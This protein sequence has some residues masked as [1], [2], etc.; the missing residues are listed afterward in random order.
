MFRV[1]AWIA[2]IGFGGLLCLTPVTAILALGWT[3]RL[4]QRRIERRWQGKDGHPA[5]QGPSRSFLGAAAHGVWQTMRMGGLGLIGPF[6]LTSPAGVLWIFSWWAGWNNSFNK[7]YEQAWVGP[8][9][10]L[11]GVGFWIAAMMALPLAQARFAATGRLA[12][13]FE[14]RV[15]S[16]L[17]RQRPWASAAVSMAFVAA[18]GLFVVSRFSPLVLQAVIPNFNSLPENN[19]GVIARLFYF[20]VALIYFAAFVALHLLSARLYA[21]AM[22]VAVQRGEIA[23]E[24][25]CRR[26]RISAQRLRTTM[27]Q[28]G[29]APRR[30]ASRWLRRVNFSLA[31]IAGAAA[32]LL[33]AVMLFIAQFWNHAWP[34]WLLHPLVL[35]PWVP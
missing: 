28:H 23:L 18:S 7:G 35:L 8:V 2:R 20:V 19:F 15:I 10:G 6:L 3:Y 34:L 17:W 1:A 12:S 31:G 25:L 26:E 11:L 14:L 32:W 27:P 13:V 29:G 5:P 9:S 33:V 24:R 22:V 30:T 4:M 21:G 16:R